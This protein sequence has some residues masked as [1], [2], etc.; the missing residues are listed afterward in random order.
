M[1]VIID[2]SNPTT[3]FTGKAIQDTIDAIPVGTGAV[4][5]IPA[6]TYLVN[7][8]IRI[9]KSI[10]LEGEGTMYHGVILRMREEG[11]C[12]KVS[13][14]FDNGGLL[15]RGDGTSIKNLSIYF[16]NKGDSKDGIRVRRNFTGIEVYNAP[17]VHIENV[18][19]NGES[20]NY[21][22]KFY[23]IH[24]HGENH[25]AGINCNNWSIQNCWIDGIGGTGLR[26]DG[27]NA[28]ARCAVVHPEYVRPRQYRRFQAPSG[29]SSRLF[30]SPLA[31]PGARKGVL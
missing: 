12:I 14:A 30:Y 20:S 28:V 10:I 11:V 1:K 31:T 19:I 3:A 2:N 17:A 25:D 18:L 23:G 27:V 9:N 24:I 15:S 13:K 22:E 8:T 4:V 26:V 21:G 6:G 7:N 16:E 5:Y 29:R